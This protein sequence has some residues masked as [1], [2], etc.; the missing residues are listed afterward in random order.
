MLAAE[1]A[2]IQRLEQVGQRQRGIG[3]CMGEQK[4]AGIGHKSASV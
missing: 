2:L 4:R 1:R 3:G